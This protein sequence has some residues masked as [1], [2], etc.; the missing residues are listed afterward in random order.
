MGGSWTIPL[1]LMVPQMTHGVGRRRGG[2]NGGSPEGVSASNP[3]NLNM[4]LFGKKVFVCVIK[5]QL[6]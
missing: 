4:S 2:L 3:W 1:I 6:K 5:L